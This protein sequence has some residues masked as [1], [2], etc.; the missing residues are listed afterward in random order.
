V[1]Q[2]FGGSFSDSSSIVIGE[3]PLVLQRQIYEAYFGATGIEY[4]FGRVTISGSDFSSRAYSYDDNRPG[5]FDLE[6][7]SLQPEDTSYKIPQLKLAKQIAVNEVKWFGSSWAPPAWMKTNGE[8]HNKGTLIGEPGGP[9]YKTYSKYL[10]KFLDAYKELGV[11]MWGLTVQNEPNTGLGE[12]EYAWNTCGFNSTQERDFIK[13]DLGPDLEAA[14]YLA[15]TK[16]QLMTLDHDRRYVPEWTSTVYGDPDASQYVSGLAVHW[17]VNGGLGPEVFDQVMADYPDKF[18]LYTESSVLH[19]LDTIAFGNW[20]LAEEYAW[21][22]M[23]DVTHSVAGWV[24]WNL[25]LDM[26]GGPNW[27]HVSERSAPVHINSTSGEWFKNPTFYALGHFS[28]FVTPGSVH[29]GEQVG[30][31]NDFKLGVFQRPDFGIAVVAINSLEQP[32]TVKLVDPFKGEVIIEVGA[33]SFNT[34]VYY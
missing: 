31:G 9:Y 8:L 20:A 28:K 15:P 24:D 4:V 6:Y 12:G 33:K 21:D 14:G 16:I 19:G 29:L 23:D 10:I 3:L 11:D 22:I 1:I 13:M 27:P 17:Y 32:Q 34:W 5:D 18:I 26:V 25:A 2:G 30:T 7:W